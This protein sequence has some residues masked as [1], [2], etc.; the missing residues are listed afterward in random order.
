MT[1]FKILAIRPL[2]G[3]NT[4]FLKVLKEN[5]LYSFYRD[6]KIDI[7]DGSETVSY[8][9][10]TPD[11][12]YNNGNSTP[13]I[14]VSAIV[15]KN[16]CGKSTITELIYAAIYNLAVNKKLIK[17]YIRDEKPKVIDS[18]NLDMFF[19]HEKI[20]KL[21]LNDKE[22]RLYEKVDIINKM[23][24]FYDID[25]GRLNKYWSEINDNIFF[26]SFF[27]SIAVNYSH[28]A[29]NSRQIGIWIK[30]LFHKNDG[31]QTPIV[32]NPMRTDGNIDI[33]AENHLV[34]SRLIANLLKPVDEI[35]NLNFRYITKSQIAKKIIFTYN[36]KKVEKLYHCSYDES[37]QHITVQS[38]LIELDEF[39][40]GFLYDQNI[41]RD[42]ID[43]VKSK[44][45]CTCERNNEEVNTTEMY[46]YNKLISIAKKYDPY[47]EMFA[48]NGSVLKI[49]KVDFCDFVDKLF[50]NPSH[51][52]FKL[53]QAINYLKN[54]P[55]KDFDKDSESKYT[56]D[57]EEL[58]KKLN[59]FKG[60]IIELIP[61]PIFDYD[62]ELSACIDD[63]ENILKFSDLSSGEKQLVFSVSSVLYHLN[64]LD[65]VSNGIKY[66]YVH[67][68]FDEIELYYH[69]DLQREFVKYLIDNINRLGLKNIKGINICFVTH[70]PFILSDI[71]ESNILFLKVEKGRAIQ[72]YPKLKTFS[73][74]I[75]DLLKSGFFMGN[76][77]IGEQAKDRILK[78]V[79]YLK[80]DE[81]KKNEINNEFFDRVISRQ[82]INL[83]GEP[84]LR[85]H[86]DDMWC[87]KFDEISEEEKLRNR[88]IEL[89][90]K[91]A[92][93]QN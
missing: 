7:V 47:K 85:K 62:I 61:P 16:G 41:F 81:G 26:E 79:D 53:R 31:Y 1:D 49:S 92:D 93:A 54:D 69:P 4:N 19:S 70:S 56:I 18:I 50:D 3:C 29:L 23:D 89:E 2:S 9:Q 43:I 73:A 8:E 80:I 66:R 20:Y 38:E 57:I 75:H 59:G 15:G 34:Y 48:E 14:N 10:T 64:N 28:Y 65:S 5:E 82:L 25:N 36:P 35:S 6:F 37:K 24:S 86:L 90:K 30:P 11:I 40:A 44:F 45:G 68:L 58:S 76:G 17:E 51:I 60:D 13:K 39:R 74:N 46:I 55:L 63:K 88:I 84:V 71:P 72:K 42:I 78:L 52:T 12:V 22:V 67:L 32:L 87:K 27:Y 77:M 21:T 83:I 33:N 91:L